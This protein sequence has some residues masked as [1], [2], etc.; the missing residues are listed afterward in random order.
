MT[1]TYTLTHAA[2]LDRAEY[3]LN[4]GWHPVIPPPPAHP[5]MYQRKCDKGG[6]HLRPHTRY[7]ATPRRLSPLPPIATHRAA[8]LRGVAAHPSRDLP[9][10]WPAAI[11]TTSYAQALED[12]APLVSVVTV[13]D[14]TETARALREALRA[15]ALPHVA[16]MVRGERMGAELIA[17]RLNIPDE[18]PAR[19]PLK[20]E[21]SR[22]LAMLEDL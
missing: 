22:V 5:N 9:A 14:A 19:A 21:V 13:H 20:A 12:G 8:I 15:A 17:A 10:P 6:L 2:S 4:G 11:L 16:E 18:P 3:F 7:R 1:T